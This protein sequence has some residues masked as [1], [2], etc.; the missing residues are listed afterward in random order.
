MKW[1]VA[2]NR[3]THTVAGENICVFPGWGHFN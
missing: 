3:I 1:G 2:Q